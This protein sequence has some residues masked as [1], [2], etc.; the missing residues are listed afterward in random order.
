MK[1]DEK[2]RL[3]I[4]INTAMQHDNELRL[5]AIMEGRIELKE[6]DDEELIEFGQDCWNLP[7]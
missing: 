3:S 4:I 2:K 1:L 7:L 6:M 5:E